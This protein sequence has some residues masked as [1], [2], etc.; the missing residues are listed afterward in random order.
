MLSK[1]FS[2]VS[3]SNDIILLHLEIVSLSQHFRSKINGKLNYLR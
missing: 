1:L 3:H 2:L